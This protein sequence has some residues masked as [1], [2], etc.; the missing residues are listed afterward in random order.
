MGFRKHGEG[1]IIRDADQQKTAAKADW[2]D[3]DQRALDS[4]NA[5]ADQE[6]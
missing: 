2:T 4:E 6:G 5:A 3:D 1:D